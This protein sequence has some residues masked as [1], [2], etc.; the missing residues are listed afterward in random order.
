MFSLNRA[1]LLAAPSLALLG[2]C[3]QPQATAQADAQHEAPAI[4]ALQWEAPV[5]PAPL[6]FAQALDEA[7]SLPAPQDDRQ[8]DLQEISLRLQALELRCDALQRDPTP[9][10]RSAWIACMEQ[11]DE[12]R[13]TEQRLRD[14][15]HRAQRRPFDAWAT[16]LEA[17][18]D[19][20]DRL[21]KTLVPAERGARGVAANV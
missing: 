7:P 5:E 2:A 21:E 12:A 9:L 8:R 6:S 20:L 15:L 11:L 19:A 16:R 10:R 17:L 4:V 13:R 18:Q 14:E 3:Q 1:L